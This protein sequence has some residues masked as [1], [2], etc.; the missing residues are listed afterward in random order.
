MKRL[1]T[2]P[3]KRNRSEQVRR[4]RIRNQRDLEA[5]FDGLYPDPHP[6]PDDFLLDKNDPSILEFHPGNP[7][8]REED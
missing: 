2:R 6:D 7:R 8:Y 3:V 5:V 4:I 1:N